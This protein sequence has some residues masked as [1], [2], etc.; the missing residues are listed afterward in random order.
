MGQREH[1]EADGDQGQAGGEPDGRTARLPPAVQVA[2]TNQTFQ[3]RLEQLRDH[4]DEADRDGDRQHRPARVVGQ[5]YPARELGRPQQHQ[6]HQR[7]DGPRGR[8]RRWRVG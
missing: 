4:P 3:R 5:A 6:Y 2:E 7:P 8:A 1:G